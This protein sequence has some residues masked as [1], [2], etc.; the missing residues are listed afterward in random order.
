M[1]FA[2]EAVLLFTAV[3]QHL[4]LKTY[5][6]EMLKPSPKVIKYKNTLKV[7]IHKMYCQLPQELKKLHNVR[8]F[9]SF[10]VELEQRFLAL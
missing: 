3:Q 6:I 4:L 10:L 9:P 5:V 1:S 7:L 2:F 8:S